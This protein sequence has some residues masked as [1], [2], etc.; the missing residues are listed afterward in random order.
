MSGIPTFAADGRRLRPYSLRA[1][2]CLLAQ[3]RVAVE[4]NHLGVIVR[5]TLRPVDEGRNPIGVAPVLLQP[6]AGTRYSFEIRCGD[7]KIWQHHR[8]PERA[9]F[10][11]VPASI[12][13]TQPKQ[14]A[15]VISIDRLKRRASTSERRFA[16]AA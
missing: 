8:V 3:H 16:L 7:R 2:E 11:C 15:N 4:R 10:E 6:K 12:M 5:A 1:I 9:A 14:R 13:R